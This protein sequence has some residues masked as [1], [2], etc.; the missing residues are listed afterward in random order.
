MWLMAWRAPE[1]VFAET[2]RAIGRFAA[3]EVDAPF[4]RAIDWPAGV[5]RPAEAGRFI[6]GLL[7]VE[8]FWLIERL[9]AGECA[10]EAG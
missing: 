8:R 5:V 9:E 10:A 3:G 4:E 1:V 7:L 2:G 6:E